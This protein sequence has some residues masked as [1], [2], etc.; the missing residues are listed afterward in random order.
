M[1]TAMCGQVGAQFDGGSLGWPERGQKAVTPVRREL[2][3]FVSA[4]ESPPSIGV[5]NE[6]PYL[7]GSPCSFTKSFSSF[8]IYHLLSPLQYHTP[9]L[10]DRGDKKHGLGTV[11][12]IGRNL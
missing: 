4:L 8:F 1:S 12:V 7:A 11:V 10:D 2:P 6:P 5:L 9:Y 3:P